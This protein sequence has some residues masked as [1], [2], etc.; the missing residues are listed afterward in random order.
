MDA[1]VFPGQGSQKPA[2]GAAWV[3]S[4]SWAVVDEVSA[5]LGRD[6][7]ALLLEADAAT[8]QATSNA[9]VA[10]FALG[11][12]LLDAARNAGLTWQVAAGH[13]LGEYTALV[14]A[15]ILPVADA[16]TLVGERAAAM[17][18][19]ADASPGTMAA[20]LAL[21]TEAVEACCAAAGG[22]AWIAND[23]APGQIVVAG[24][25]D[26]VAAAA[27]AA[28][29]RGGK[30][31]PLAVGAAFHTPLMA[32]AQPRLDQAVAAAPFAPGAVDVVANVDATPHGQ[33]GEW[34]ALLSAQLCSPVRWRES[35]LRLEAM[36]VTRIIELGPGGVLGGMVKRIAPDLDRTSAST[37]DELAALI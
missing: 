13:S 37:P 19:A 17:Q 29:E 25:A 31:L 33:P 1:V 21:D 26:G 15:D 23:N 34:P 32:T 5:T 12:V 4:P 11:L 14:A 30:V 27:A 8:L 22:H 6:V 18:V 24:T 9:Q 35:V 28:K 2:M 20:V 10:A 36:G 7:G 16:T 3:A